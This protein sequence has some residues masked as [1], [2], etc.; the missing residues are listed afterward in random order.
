[1]KG[2]L[3]WL[4]H[5]F[6]R[7]YGSRLNPLYQ[8]GVLVVLLSVVLLLTGLYLLLFYRIG[9]PWGSVNRVTFHLTGRKTMEIDKAKRRFPDT[10]CPDDARL[11]VQTQSFYYLFPGI[12]HAVERY[13][14]H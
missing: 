13:K 12:D 5:A 2:A 8:S 14:I 6:D 11:I 9:E 7:L 1:M 4:D 10:I 3:A